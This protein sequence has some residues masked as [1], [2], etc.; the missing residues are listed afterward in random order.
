MIYGNDIWDLM[1]K[2]ISESYQRAYSPAF[3]RRVIFSLYLHSCNWNDSTCLD[4]K[5]SGFWGNILFLTSEYLNP[6]LLRANWILAASMN[7]ES[8]DHT[9]SDFARSFSPLVFPPIGLQLATFK[10]LVAFFLSLMWKTPY[11]RLMSWLYCPLSFSL[12]HSTIMCIRGSH[13]SSIHPHRG[14]VPASFD[15]ALEKGHL[16]GFLSPT[17]FPSINSIVVQHMLSLCSCAGGGRQGSP[18][19]K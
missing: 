5:A 3:E 9:K 19:R 13:S 14:H 16:G 10:C 6:M 1:A 7:E 15:L 4:I 18:S 12:L 8:T 2:L 11:C 17:F